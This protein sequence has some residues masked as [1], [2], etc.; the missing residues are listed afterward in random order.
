[1]ALRPRKNVKG[2]KRTTWRPRR[3]MNLRSKAAGGVEFAS[4]KQNIELS[5]DPVNSVY[6]IDDINLS[7]FDRLVQIARSYQYFRFTKVIMKFK[8]LVDTFAI[9][10]TGPG[11]FQSVPYLYTLINKSDTLNSVVG[12]FNGLRDAGCRP[13]RFDDK[14]ITVAWRPTVAQGVSLSETNNTMSYATYR[15]SPWL[16]TNLN[17]MV[18]GGSA[19]WAASTVPHLGLMYGVEQANSG[20]QVLPYSV[21]IEVH[22]QFKKPLQFTG[23]SILAPALKKEIVAR[24]DPAGDSHL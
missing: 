18:P 7:Q 19:V 4:A 6:R 14:T 21:E 12:G 13:R 20:D 22:A 15:T 16:S 17:V 1:M 23:D 2:K 24:P 8:P 9:Q 3:R 11:T 5:N 10:G